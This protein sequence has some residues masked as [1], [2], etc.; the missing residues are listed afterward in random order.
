MTL[1]MTVSV[2]S[3]AF[4]SRSALLTCISKSLPSI[5]GGKA[6]RFSGESQ[7]M[8]LTATGNKSTYNIKVRSTFDGVGIFSFQ[9]FITKSI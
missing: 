5:L 2:R 4:T 1:F 9:D 7:S 6:F 8:A 3:K